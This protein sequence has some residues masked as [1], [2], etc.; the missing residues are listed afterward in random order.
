M[1]QI[2]LKDSYDLGW[3]A[4]DQRVAIFN[5]SADSPVFTTFGP[6]SPKCLV[7]LAGTFS[8]L[9]IYSPAGAHPNY[10]ATLY[11]NGVAT[12]MVASITSADDTATDATHTVSVVAGDDIHLVVNVSPP[13][14]GTGYP[15]NTSIQFEGAK[16]FYPSDVPTGSIATTNELQCGALGNGY[17]NTF[18]NSS[19]LSTGYSIC[20]VAGTIDGLAI[21]SYAGAPG[22]GTWTLYINKNNVLQ[23]GTGGTVNTAC[24]LTGASTSATSTFTLPI[25]LGDHVEFYVKRSG[26][27]APFALAQFGV[28]CIF[29]PTTPNLY[30]A[31]G[32]SNDANVAAGSTDYK[33]MRSQQAIAIESISKC[34]VGVSGF[35]VSGLYIEL[36]IAPGPGK[37]VVLTLQKSGVATA[38]TVTI[39]GTN[40]KGNITGLNI[41]FGP[42]DYIDL[43][44]VY[45]SGASTLIGLWWGLSGEVKTD[46][47]GIY[48]LDSTATHDHYNGGIELK[49]PD[50]TIRTSIL[51]S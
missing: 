37:N 28:A 41:P 3:G 51:G 13:G 39:S 27:N 46:A 17:F 36:P 19:Q 5:G 33:W 11:K 30:M 25:A 40:A 44:I 31:T 1:K 48:F 47:S 50:P 4:G 32:G 10:T 18:Q 26:I 12:S 35:T 24:V 20:S 7:P 42:E 34:P 29:N 22:A 21:K 16:N 43:K 15:L 45:D 23:D 9:T 49:I 8:N 38:A 6:D 14:S 2:I